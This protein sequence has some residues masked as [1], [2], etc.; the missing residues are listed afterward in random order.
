M[1]ERSTLPQILR[2]SGRVCASVIVTLFLVWP[3]LIVI[4]S[5]FVLSIGNF[6]LPKFLLVFLLINNHKRLRRAYKKIL[7]KGKT[8]VRIEGIP[9]VELLDHLFTVGSF[10]RD[11]IKRK[12][13]IPHHRYQ[14]LAKKLESLGILIRG[15]NNARILNDAYSRQDIAAI[16]HNKR[17]AVDLEPVLTPIGSPREGIVYTIDPT[18]EIIADR[19]AE[20]LTPTQQGFETV[21]IG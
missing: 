14:S 16:L 18:S 5:R 8:T 15:E 12:F 7:S 6:A 3:D 10:K 1:I 13:G 4:A 19:V 2:A 17:K 9:S 20:Y 21:R 11:D